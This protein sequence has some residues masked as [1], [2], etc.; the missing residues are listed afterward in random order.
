M[1][2]IGGSWTVRWLH[3]DVAEEVRMQVNA[4]IAQFLDGEETHS[5]TA[6]AGRIARNHEMRAIVGDA[7]VWHA[8]TVA[9]QNF[10][11]FYAPTHVVMMPREVCNEMVIGDDFF[12]TLSY[13][14]VS[15][16]LPVNMYFF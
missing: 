1:A 9:G 16:L 13:E 12:G 5:F 2:V 4:T 11:V 3:T 10:F 8:L 7:V 14:T 15:A 6:F